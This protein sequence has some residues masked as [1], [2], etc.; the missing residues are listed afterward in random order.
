MAAKKEEETKALAPQGTRALA[1]NHDYGDDM[2][3]MGTGVAPGYEHQTTD[4]AATPWLVLLQQMSP[5]VAQKKL[6]GADAGLF[7]NTVTQSLHK[8]VAFVGS[9][10]RHE[11]V[12][13]KDRDA[14][15]GGLVGRHE[16]DSPVVAKAKAE[17]KFGEYKTPEGNDL[18][19]TYYVF[20]VQCV[21][22][23]L[24][25][26]TALNA[27]EMKL[28]DAKDEKAIKEMQGIVLKEWL[29]LLEP[30]GMVVIAFS[31]TKI[32]AYKAWTGQVRSHT[33]DVAGEKFMPPLYAHVARMHAEL[34]PFGKNTAWVTKLNP[35]RGA[36]RNSLLP[37][38]HPAFQMA[39]T[40]KQM[41]DRGEAKVDYGKQKVGGDAGAPQEKPF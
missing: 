3:P 15:D 37:K 7:M 24:A 9:T 5:V 30:I 31:S 25:G 13:W 35:A 40:C 21:W 34:E 22:G 16:I 2:V 4:D 23:G 29:N 36:V 38:E 11:F 12:E 17:C 27:A 33:I 28:A 18:V 32:K 14:G 26:F 8:E 41:V 10:T 20:G 19:E 1:S 39:K 6:E